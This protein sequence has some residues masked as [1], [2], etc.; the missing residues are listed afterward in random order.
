M[1][2][3]HRAIA[4]GAGLEEAVVD[5]IAAREAPAQLK[6]DE[7]VVYRFCKELLGTK[8]V[9]DATFAVTKEAFGDRGVVD[10]MGT[11]AYYQ[12]VAMALNVDRYPVPEGPHHAL[13]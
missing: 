13:T 12:L 2:H 7:A 8:Q 11:L 3:A 9:S 6:H 10:L 5:A 1:W 4:I